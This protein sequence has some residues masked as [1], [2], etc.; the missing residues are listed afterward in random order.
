MLS[1]GIFRT[2][3]QVCTFGYLQRAIYN[4][5]AMTT[6]HN[7]HTD[8]D[9]FFFTSWMPLRDKIFRV[10]LNADKNQTLGLDFEEFLNA[11]YNR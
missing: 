10:M 1:A 4:I 2:R 8:T 6:P 9:H 11:L 3:E 7:H 5:Y